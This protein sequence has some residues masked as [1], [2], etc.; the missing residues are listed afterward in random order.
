[1]VYEDPTFYIQGG[2]VGFAYRQKNI[3]DRLTVEEKNRNER[4]EES[5]DR[6]QDN[7]T[8]PTRNTVPSRK[9]CRSEMKQYRGK[10]SIFKRPDAPPPRFNNKNIPDYRRNPHKWIKYSLGDV[11]QEDMSDRSNTAAALSFLKEMQERKRHEEM[12]V[13]DSEPNQTPFK[14]PVNNGRTVFQ[15]GTRLCIFSGMASGENATDDDAKACFRSSKLIMPEY[16][17]GV[18]KK[19]DKKKHEKLNHLPR[20]ESIASTIK[21]QHL[22]EEDN[23][24]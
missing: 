12:E 11:S 17:V 5:E 22:T 6:S 18:T 3:F 8:Q 7:N 24:E 20:N 9:R 19:K 2:D 4:Q 1:M 23:G 15:R 13:D 21:L 10:E 14:Q 16:I